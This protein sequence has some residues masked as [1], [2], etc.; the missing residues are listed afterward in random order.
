M[1]ACIFHVV[2]K[3]PERESRSHLSTEG[4]HVSLTH[5]IFDPKPPSVGGLSTF[6]VMEVTY[7]KILYVL[8]FLTEKLKT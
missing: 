6:Q 3:I 4:I 2:K 7:F 5:A 8:E 1:R